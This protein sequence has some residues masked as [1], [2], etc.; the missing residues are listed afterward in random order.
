MNQPAAIKSRPDDRTIDDA[1]GRRDPV[2]LEG[3]LQEEDDAEEEDEAANPGEEFDPEKI[4][5]IDRRARFRDGSSAGGG[6]AA[7][8]VQAA[9]RRS[10]ALTG[11]GKGGGTTG[12]QPVALTPAFR[13]RCFLSP[14]TTAGLTSG[15]NRRDG[16]RLRFQTR[17]A[18]GQFLHRSSP[19]LDLA[20]MRK[21]QRK[22]N[23]QRRDKT[24]RTRQG[25][26][27]S[28]SCG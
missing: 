4:F 19:A 6:G 20:R 1:H 3:V 16:A 5:P 26:T 7:R 18:R 21:D 14:S 11:T 12:V 28:I 17:Q 25:M 2:V 10:D 13:R 15:S 9:G 24:T 8:P 22:R 23:Q 27:G